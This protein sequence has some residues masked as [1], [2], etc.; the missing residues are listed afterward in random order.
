MKSL[1]PKAIITLNKKK[2]PS[3]NPNNLGEIRQITTQILRNNSVADYEYEEFVEEIHNQSSH[4]SPNE[5]LN[6]IVQNPS[7]EISKIEG[8]E[9]IIG[10]MEDKVK[11]NSVII[12]AW[13][14][15][16]VF[17]QRLLKKTLE[18]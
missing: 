5:E 7:P 6:G 1:Q 13:E 3:N 16:S 17:K 15:K 2:M 10:E 9:Q 12:S 18:K 8:L 11:E 14:N 4:N